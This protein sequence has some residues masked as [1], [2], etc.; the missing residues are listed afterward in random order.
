LST[1]LKSS[2]HKNLREIVLSFHLQ[3]FTNF[4]IKEVLEL[5]IFRQVSLLTSFNALLIGDLEFLSLQLFT[6]SLLTSRY[7]SVNY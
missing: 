1:E 4:P 5:L 2:I 3:I 6:F 7:L